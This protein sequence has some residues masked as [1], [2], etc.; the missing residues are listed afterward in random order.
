MVQ[1]SGFKSKIK[2]I[3]T[4][5]GPI[6]EAFPPMSVTLTLED[7]IDISRGDMIV[8]ENNPPR[9]TQDLEV[10]LCWLNTNPMQLGGK[11]VLRHTTNECRAMIKDVVY[12]MDINNLTRNEGDKSAGTNDIVKVHLRTTKPVIHDSY[13]RNRQTG[14]LILVDETTNETV[15]AGM[16]V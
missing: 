1:P 14:S 12:K 15:A 2:S 9:V 3:D 10:M 13:R 8:R 7:D 6:N 5:N 16:I 4:L 11:Y